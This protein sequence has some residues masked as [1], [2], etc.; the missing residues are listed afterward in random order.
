MI[1]TDLADLVFD[2]GRACKREAR[3]LALGLNCL[4]VGMFL[5]TA[6]GSAIP[7]TTA[8]QPAGGRVRLTFWSMWNETEPQAAVLRKY[9][10]GF[11]KETGIKVNL[12]F[13]GRENQTLVRA[14][15]QAGTTIDLMDEDGASL[16]GGL[17]TEGQGYALD[18]FL[19]Q[20]AWGE[21]GTPFRSIFR[22]GLLERFQLDGQTYLIP[23]TL[24]TYALWYDKR[25]LKAAGIDNLPTTWDDFLAAADK[26]KAK[27]IA[28]LAQEAGVNSYNLLW[29]VYL[30]ER[31]KGP[32]FLLKASEDKPGAAWD[33]PAFLEAAR[34]ERE[35][36][37]KR[38]IVEGA[39]DFSFPQGQQTLADSL[40]AMELSGSWLPSELKPA[41]DAGF[42]WGGLS[43]P[44]VAGG[45]GRGGDLLAGQLNFMILKNSAHPKEAFDF[46]R[47]TLSKD[48][49]QRWADE[50][51][52]GVPR[53]DVKF[54]ALIAEA[55]TLF[56]HA[57][58]FFDEVDGV[59]FKYAEYADQ[60]LLPTHDEMFVGPSPKLT[61]E[62]FVAK[63]KAL[64]AAYWKTH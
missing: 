28:P 53:K 60:V 48:N 56:N 58:T 59:T 46:I 23:H 19:N 1:S 3:H 5:L 43:F 57:T 7:S 11:E 4:L 41:V 54:P 16:A 15:L 32:G 44:T 29:Y 13:N 47:Y 18:G 9:A 39:E 55:E 27:G 42:Q 26:I 45:E 37:D 8:T 2:F 63:M 12:T 40:S 33:D 22:P 31:L 10:A 36:W 61:P 51:L 17:M 20:D 62:E 52:S 64:T 30:V 21:P 25:D 24:I 35:L 6:C 34:M 38:Y 50:T 14:A 49:V